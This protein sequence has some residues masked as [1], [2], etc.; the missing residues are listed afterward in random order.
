MKNS[1]RLARGETFSFELE[2]KKNLGQNFLTDESI[3][4]QIVAQ[5]NQ[6]AERSQRVC[7]EIGPGSG[8]LTIQLLKAGWTVH[9]IEK[10]PRAVEGLRNSLGKEFPNTFTVTETDI[11]RLDP[12]TLFSEAHGSPLCIGNIP[13]YIT[14]EILFWFLAEEKNFCAAILM[15]QKEVA[16]RLAASA[17]DRNYG[18]LTVRM[19]L[20]CEVEQVLVAPARA[21][22]PPPKVDSAVV[23]LRPRSLVQINPTEIAGFEK[24][25]AMLFSARRKML[26]KTLQH[27]AHELKGAGISEQ[28]FTNLEKQAEQQLAVVFTQRPEELSPEALLKLFRLLKESLES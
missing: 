1:K 23:E 18:R 11:L 26:R 20:A 8:A 21:F 27:F 15:V 4:A 7:L 6:H 22:V 13:Y 19:Q 12:K 24:F 10:D 14:S 2:T 28:Q 25:T 3:L 5:A 17:G 9:A 16:E